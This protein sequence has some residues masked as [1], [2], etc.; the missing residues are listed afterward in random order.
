MK[1]LKYT[2]KTDTLFK[3][4]FVQHQDL[5]KAF[6]STL[7]GISLE[8]IESFLVVNPE[9][10]PENLGDKF[11]RLD[12]HMIVNGQRVD[13]EVQVNN[14]GD[15]PERV[16]LYWAKDF[17]SALAAG[18]SYSMLPRTIVISLVD[19][20]LFDCSE[21]HS[22]FQILEVNR[23]TLL[24]DKMGLYFFELPKLPSEISNDNMLLLW[25]S[26]FKAN[27]E[28]E[29]EKIR[30][31]EVPVMNQALNAY[32]AITVSPEFREMERLRAKARHDE[33]QAL[34]HAEQKGIE[35][36]IKRGIEK[37][38]EKGIERGIEKGR[39]EEKLE[40]ARK[41]KSMGLSLNQISQAS[42][43]SDSEIENL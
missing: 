34:Y 25:L 12:I 37:G 32:D 31:L 3:M 23:H 41:L 15:Y 4:L 33:A 43:L 42:G 9:I 28:E 20:S 39:Q 2:F 13:L 8:S 1:K 30:A 36:G 7:L 38:I 17:S 6:V 27:T 40:M 22:F 14:G 5:L 21:Y 29:L 35:K 10:Q 26:L 19:F 24:S 16:L 11:C 18:Q